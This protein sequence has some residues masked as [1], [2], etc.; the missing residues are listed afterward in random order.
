MSKNNT[1]VAS[2]VTGADIEGRAELA[3]KLASLKDK[4]KLADRAK[5]EREEKVARLTEIRDT[6]NPQIQVESLRPANQ[7]E[8]VNGKP[9]KGWVVEITCEIC[10]K[11]RLIN[12]QDAF[13]AKTCMAHTKDRAKDRAKAR[14][15][16][17]KISGLLQLDPDQLANQIAEYEAKLAAAS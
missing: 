8:L 9:A 7:G 11:T 13:Q 15:E 6:K 3:R 4:A 12:T 17:A 1:V 5:K 2:T 10:N 14:R 16:E